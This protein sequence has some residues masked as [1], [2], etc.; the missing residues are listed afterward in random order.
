MTE[1]KNDRY[2]QQTQT[3]ISSND[4]IQQSTQQTS[5]PGQ[6]KINIEAE[7]IEEWDVV[8]TDQRRPQFRYNE[9][10]GRRNY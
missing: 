9:N 10:Y 5:D 2:S 8:V 3:E 7:E 1:I 4:S 6:H